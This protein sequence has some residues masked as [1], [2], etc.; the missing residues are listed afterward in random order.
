MNPA[1]FLAE[2]RRRR[3]FAIISHPD[4]GKTTLTEKLLLYTGKIMEAGEVK[5]KANR[6]KTVSDWMEL[7]KQRGISISSSV[8][9][10]DFEKL[11][12]NLLDTPGHKDFSEDTYRTLMAA[13]TA[14][15]VID[16]AKGVETQTKKLFEVC[17]MRGIPIL[18]FVN[19]M[20]R[21][22]RDPF[23]LMKELEDVL[24]L[25]ANPVTWPIGMGDRFKGVYHRLRNEFHFFEPAEK[26]GERA[27]MQVLKCDIKDSALLKYIDED[28]QAKLIE[29][30]ELLDGALGP[31]DKAD[32][33]QGTVSPTLFG[34]ARNN[35]GISSFLEIFHDFTPA[36]Q[37]KEARPET[38]KPEDPDFSGFVFK[39][40]ANMDKNHRDR[41]AFIRICSGRFERDMDVKISRNQKQVRLA[42]SKQ[43]M[44]QER[45]TVDE[46]YAGDII[47]VHDSGHFKI[48]DTVFTGKGVEFLG[49]PQFSPECFGRLTL[50][51]PM[52]RKQLQKG[53]S[54]LCEEGLVQMF[55]DP[56]VGGQDPILG[57][58]GILQFDVMM[59]RLQDEYRVECRLERLPYEIARWVKAAPGSNVD[60]P[61]LDMRVP[62]VKDVHDQW[63]VL[64]KSDW[65]L[66]FLQ[67]NLPPTLQW[68]NNS[69][70]AARI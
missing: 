14:V 60:I 35:F 25:S 12:I 19:K 47:G 51:D 57:V 67:K 58:V 43:F 38:V 22:A 70:E 23:E 17:R 41:M 5:A 64:C 24:K 40:Q 28:Q 42:H 15:M 55:L 56:K 9:Q 6:R 53:I 68:Y 20:D 37:P 2:V 4:A 21:E 66:Q 59:F 49:I 65:E 63:V 13:D 10:F 26:V 1:H 36:P 33:L 69:F 61:S 3:T 52:K 44:A 29:D 32:F 45:A 16:A 30:M 7:E 31:V 11:K 27:Q 46:A 48:G 54:E 39:I 8:L 34:S 50:R 62:L 18:T